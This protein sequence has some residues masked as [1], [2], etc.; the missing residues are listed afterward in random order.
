MNML[1]FDDKGGGKGGMKTPKHADVIYEW[2]LTLFTF[3]LQY[4]SDSVSQGLSTWQ[5][6]SPHD[7]TS[8][9]EDRNG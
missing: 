5:A 9:L 7:C 2:S 8:T 6:P 4:K 3:S 1:T